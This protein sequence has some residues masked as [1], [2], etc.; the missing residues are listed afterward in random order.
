[1]QIPRQRTGESLGTTPLYGTHAV[2]LGA[3]IS[4]LLAARVL[5]EHF[6]QVTVVERDR[7]P[8]DGRP[9]RGVPQGRHAHL[10]L[11]PGA[12]VLDEL[13]PGV[14]AELVQAGVPVARSL[15][16]LHFQIG[17]HVFCQAIESP[18][19]RGA[20]GGLYEPSRPLLEATLLRRVRALRNVD[21]M[22]GCDVLGLTADYTLKRVTGTR[23][24][25]RM[26]GLAQDRKSV[27]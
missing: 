26:V 13:F 9:R 10:L 19:G 24:E 22:D 12:R 17:G 14:L 21:V 5:A 6:S 18:S 4:G 3:S 23:V 20:M 7:L 2:V 8:V 16:E 27:V 1:M 15:H 11:A 25:P